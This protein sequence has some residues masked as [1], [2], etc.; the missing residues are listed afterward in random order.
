MTDLI[1]A[2]VDLAAWLAKLIADLASGK[3]TEDEARA[4]LLA[5]GLS[6]TETETDAELAEQL[7][8][9]GDG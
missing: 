6:I 1:K 9:L 8:L 2:L 4:E 5:L 7:K 3:K